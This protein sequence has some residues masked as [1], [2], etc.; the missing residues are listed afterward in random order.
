MK[1]RWMYTFLNFDRKPTFNH[2]DFVKSN[3][4]CT[5][6]LPHIIDIVKWNSPL[7]TKEVISPK[8]SW[9]KLWHL[10]TCLISNLAGHGTSWRGTED[11]YSILELIYLFIENNRGHIWSV[12][13]VYWGTTANNTLS[14]INK[15]TPTASSSSIYLDVTC[16]FGLWIRK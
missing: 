7:E 12:G 13:F 6:S 4:F 9:R 2:A 11:E 15:T 8:L 3:T 5:L 14:V 16:T 10:S 1:Y